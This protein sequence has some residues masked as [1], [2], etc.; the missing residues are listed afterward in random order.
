MYSVPRLALGNISTIAPLL[1]FAYI[2]A[3]IFLIAN[4]VRILKT[5]RA[6]T[7]ELMPDLLVAMA[8]GALLIAWILQAAP[9]VWQSLM[10]SGWMVVFIGASFMVFRVTGRREPFYAYAAVGIGMLGAATSAELGGAALTIAYT[11]EAALVALLT[12]AITRDRDAAERVSWLFVIP[13]VLSVQSLWWWS[14][15]SAVIGTDFFVLL[16]LGLFL[17]GIGIFFM[18]SY[19]VSGSEASGGSKALTV[20]GSIY[21]YALIWNALHVAFPGRGDIATGT[22]LVI[23]T[24]IGLITYFSGSTQG[25]GLRY[26]GG[27]LLAFVVGRLLVVDIWQMDL[28]GRIVV[29]FLVG[30]LLITTA[31]IGRRFSVRKNSAQ[32]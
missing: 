29:F 9:E 3:A 31:F 18:K 13:I 16:L 30:T 19:K 14:W 17:T 20:V 7:K 1:P 6:A 8:N 21:L 26:Y 10:L 11:V 27:A 4:I 24:V 23:F 15:G 25:K 5:S 22:S 28:A 12:M 32:I 2:F